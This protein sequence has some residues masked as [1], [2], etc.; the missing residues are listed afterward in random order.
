MI[1]TEMLANSAIEEEVSRLVSGDSTLFG[2]AI[3]LIL[4][5]LSLTLGKLDVVESRF[6]LAWSGIATIMLSVLAA[7]GT[8]RAY[9]SLG[10]PQSFYMLCNIVDFHAWY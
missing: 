3:M 7:F 9:R 2:G 6:L 5:Y 4:I 10:A 1:R 8:V